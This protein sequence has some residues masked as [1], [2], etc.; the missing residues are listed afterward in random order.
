[1]R[2]ELLIKIEEE[3]KDV[4]M[5]MVTQAAAIAPDS[6]VSMVLGKMV[7]EEADKTR[8]L[9]ATLEIIKFHCS[10]EVNLLMIMSFKS[11]YIINAFVFLLQK[12][13]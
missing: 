6:A 4:L 13:T 3:N 2:K 10:G 12:G 11:M 7:S 9:H 8:F 5:S 1:M